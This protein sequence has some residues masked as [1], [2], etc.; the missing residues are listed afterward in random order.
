MRGKKQV[1][2]EEPG[3][4]PNSFVINLSVN[5]SY[6]WGALHKQLYEKHRIY[7]YQT[8]FKKIRCPQQT[9]YFFKV[10]LTESEIWFVWMYPKAGT[11]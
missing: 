3:T 11:D 7:F 9:P 1:K 2:W 4:I 5:L 8:D 10:N 6:F